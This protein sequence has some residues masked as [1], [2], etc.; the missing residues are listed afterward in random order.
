MLSIP[1]YPN[2]KDNSHCVQACL[3][4]ALKYYFPKKTYSLTKLD[5]ATNHK[6]NQWDTITMLFLASLHF[7]VQYYASF[8]NKKFAEQGETYLKTIWSTEVFKEQKKHSNFKREQNLIKKEL[9]DTKITSH[10]RPATMSDIKRLFAKHYTVFAAINPYTL[11]GDKGYSSHLVVI[12]A[13]NSKTITFHDPGIP[14]IKNRVS[15]LADFK[16]GLCYPDKESA[17]IIAFKPTS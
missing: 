11:D 15:T 4:M 6:S 9:K 2:T 3:K 10:N 1:F 17:T 13:I 8:N 12:T 16:R 7:Q 14:P 5:N